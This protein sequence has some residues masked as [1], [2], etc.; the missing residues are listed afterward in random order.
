MT[1]PKR[2]KMNRKFNGHNYRFV[3]GFLDKNEAQTWRDSHY[4][5]CH[6]RIIKGKSG[7]KKVG[8]KYVTAYYLYVRC[9]DR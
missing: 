2:K 7:F 6:T 4:P 1:R 9:G 8:D 3:Q 5:N